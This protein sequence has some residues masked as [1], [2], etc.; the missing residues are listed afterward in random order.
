MGSVQSLAYA[1]ATAT[2][3]KMRNHSDANVQADTLFNII[4]CS[5][6]MQVALDP[7][8]KNFEGRRN[9]MALRET[10][11]SQVGLLRNSWGGKSFRLLSHTFLTQISSACPTSRGHLAGTP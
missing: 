1:P 11:Y 4:S 9:T 3:H 8:L 7:L 6:L 10:V 5:A 2:E